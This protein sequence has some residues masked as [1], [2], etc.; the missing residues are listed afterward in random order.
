VGS[1]AGLPAVE[2]AYTDVN[3]LLQLRGLVRK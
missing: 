1:R 2:T 3:W